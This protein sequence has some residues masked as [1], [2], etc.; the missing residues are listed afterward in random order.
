MK[1]FEKWPHDR[2]GD[3]CHKIGS[4]S[5]PRGGENVYR[6]EGP[7]IIRSQN[8]YNGIFNADGLARLSEDHAEQLEGVMVEAGDVLLNITG[9]SV[10]RCCQAPEWVI[11]AR[12]NQHVAIIRPTAGFN[13]R[14]LET[15]LLF[16]SMKKRL[17]RIA[18]AGA[19]REAI[20]K[21]AIEQLEVIQPPRADQDFFA[22]IMRERE[23]LE[24][25]QQLASS[26]LDALFAS[27]QHCAFGGEL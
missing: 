7:A 9:D 4:G 19:T 22:E 24:R 11:P 1:F 13:A 23:A 8:V 26:Q 20:T 2:L 15:C 3:I 17:L 6:T 16:P 14:F 25:Q 18:G 5:T 21:P 12:V 27:L 10:A